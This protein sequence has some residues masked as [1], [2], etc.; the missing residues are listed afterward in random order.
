MIRTELLR[1]EEFKTQREKVDLTGIEKFIGISAFVYAMDFAKWL[2]K[3]KLPSVYSKFVAEFPSP[4]I[5]SIMGACDYVCGLPLLDSLFRQHAFT[6]DK[7]VKSR[8]FDVCYIAEI[9]SLIFPDRHEE[10]LIHFLLESRGYEVEW[11][12]GYYLKHHINSNQTAINTENNGI[13]EEL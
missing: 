11:T 13:K 9:L 8:C 6:T 7:E 3:L 1:D 10:R 4:S 2:L 5:K 12:L